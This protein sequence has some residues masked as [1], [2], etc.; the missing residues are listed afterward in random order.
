MASPTVVDEHGAR[1][2]MGAKLTSNTA[3]QQKIASAC[4]KYH[5][6]MKIAASS[7]SETCSCITGFE[8]VAGGSVVRPP[9]GVG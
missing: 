1:V 4:A 3:M 2:P 9:S 7:D 8:A 6:E 5:E